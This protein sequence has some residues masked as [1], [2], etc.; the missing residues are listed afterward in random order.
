MKR[1]MLILCVGSLTGRLHGEQKKDTGMPKIYLGDRG[2]VQFISQSDATAC[3]G[4]QDLEEFSLTD[5]SLGDDADL[6]LPEDMVV[7]NT[8]YARLRS[9]IEKLFLVCAVHY[10]SVQQWI[11]KRVVKLCAYISN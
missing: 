1:M 9:R 4:D 6:Q 10:C 5:G 3:Y 8:M 2:A 7:Q 11:Q